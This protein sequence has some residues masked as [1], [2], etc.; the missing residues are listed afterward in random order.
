MPLRPWRYGENHCGGAPREM[1]AK[2][3]RHFGVQSKLISLVLVASL[4]SLLFTGLLS[5]GVARQLLSEAGQERLTSVRNARTEAIQEYL[6]HLSDQVIS[7][8]ETR[9]TIDAIQR[10]GEAFKQLPDINQEQKNKLH[11]YYEQVFI[12][13]LRK[14][15]PGE[16]SASTYFPETPSERYLKHYYSTKSQTSDANQAKV[17]QINIIPKAIS[18]QDSS[19]W[20][21]VY[22]EYHHRFAHQAKRFGH[23]DVLMVDI[24]TGTVVYNA[25]GKD[26]LGT[27]LLSGPYSDSAAAI[28]FR[29]V[30]N[31][32][33][34]SIL[35]FSDFENYKPSYG[36]SSFFVG[37]NVFAD[38]KVIGVLIL[39]I[40]TERVDNLMTSDR[41]WQEV[42]M[43]NSGEVYLVGTDG[44]FRSSPRSF[45]EDPK[46]YL[47]IAKQ[48]GLSQAKVDAIK[49]SGTP[50]LIQPVKTVGARNALNGKTGTYSY[51]DYR[52]VP[53]VA[54]YEPIQFGP[55]RWG[56]IAEIDQ[57][58]LYNG[59]RRLARSLLLMAALLI[60]IITLLSLWIARAFI[61]PI[62][63]LLE[64]T[65]MISS[66]QYNIQIPVAAE[67]EFGDLATGFNAMSDRLAERDDRLR[68]QVEENQQLLLSI[69][70][71]SAASR[72]QQGSQALAEVH[73]SVSVLYAE[74][75]GWNELSQSL[76]PEESINLLNELTSAMDATVESFDVEKLQDVG[77]GYLAVSGLSRPRI[78]HEKRAVDCAL[79]LMQLL[80]RF[81][82][83]HS[84]DLSLDIGLH[85]GP[86]TTGVTRGERLSFDIWGQTIH[87]ARG[88][89]ASPKR[90]AIQVTASIV[91]ALHGLYVFRALPAMAVK[92]LG[93]LPIWELEGSQ[94]P[95]AASENALQEV[96]QP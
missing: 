57:S 51:T 69:L 94:P 68:H 13:R 58:E 2:Y 49:K 72:L 86:L 24:N 5:F 81:N 66:G 93:D 91:E 14:L 55:F 54:A 37:T 76:P 70:P 11:A 47:A 79:A 22:R 23:Q 67:D 65:E 62:R 80:R 32:R 17:G 31:S 53:V 92:G 95:P 45:L 59:I 9:M 6:E 77:T 8:S 56:L 82:Q 20:G 16:P 34:P 19:A 27:N 71:G 96:G 88:I 4:A 29:K 10:F 85:A 42:G 41:Q 63:R 83:N 35:V 84:V 75:E 26:D 73:P 40:S 90:M 39:Q 61:R 43:G 25:S 36:E 50:V 33:D 60:P 7:L 18:P 28:V 89:H 3:F 74:I 48:N 64:A 15:I 78:D 1:P 46:S 30:K 38:G 12:P 44:T 52:G 21:A 87:I